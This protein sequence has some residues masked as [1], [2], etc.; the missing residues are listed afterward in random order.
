MLS[1]FRLSYL[2]K[3]GDCWEENIHLGWRNVVWADRLINQESFHLYNCL[4]LDN[5]NTNGKTQ[6]LWRFFYMEGGE[7]PKKLPYSEII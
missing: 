4:T 5:K 1:L 2:Q 7:K 3:E 6:E